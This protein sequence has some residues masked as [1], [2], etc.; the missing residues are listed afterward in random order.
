MIAEIS[1][2][3]SALIIAVVFLLAMFAVVL[4]YWADQEGKIEERHHRRL[5]EELKSQPVGGNIWADE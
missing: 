5:L 1:H 3:V 2:T 4:A